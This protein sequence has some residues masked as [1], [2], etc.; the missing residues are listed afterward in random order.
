MIVGGVF[1]QHTVHHQLLVFHAIIQYVHELCLCLSLFVNLLYSNTVTSSFCC[2][3]HNPLD[4]M[5]RS[6]LHV[7]QDV[8]V[9]LRSDE[10]PDQCYVPKKLEY[11]WYVVYVENIVSPLL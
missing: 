11:T 2:V 5:G 8:D 10:P 6:F 7:P 4:Y 9:N 1:V 3:V